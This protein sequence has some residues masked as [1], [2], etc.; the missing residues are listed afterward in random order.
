MMN[1]WSVGIF[2]FNEVEVLDFAGP[3][4]V[5]S[6][7]EVNEEKTFTVYTVS[8]NGEMITARNGL[9]VQ[10][11]YSIENLPPV[12]IL[13]IP[14]GLGAREYEIK[15]E[16]VIKW[17][18]QQMKEVKLMTSVCTGALLLA[19]AGLLAGLKATT[20]WAS[21]EKF[22]NEFQNVE[23]IEN[24]K[25]VDEGHII[26]SAGISAGINMAFHIVKNLLGVHV[27]EDTA[28]RMEYDISLPN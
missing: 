21:I 3:F 10:P 19:K 28:K 4:E 26:T 8:E 13:I 15:N 17:I 24:V 20:H 22:K 14:G 23:V 2:L 16:I 6:V 11:D 9:K 18:G 25:F 1:K 7:T 12:D 27:A 5:F